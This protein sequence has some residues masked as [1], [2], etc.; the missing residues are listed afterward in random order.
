MP[1]I[2]PNDL[3]DKKKDS[4]DA[5]QLAARHLPSIRKKIFVVVC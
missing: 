5:S 1:I 4:E 2:C 3:P